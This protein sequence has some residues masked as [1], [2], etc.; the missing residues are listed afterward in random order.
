MYSINFQANDLIEFINSSAFKQEYGPSLLAQSVTNRDSQMIKVLL[1]RGISINTN[2]MVRGN[3]Y[4]GHVN[5]YSTPLLHKVVLNSD[6]EMVQILLDHG[7]DPNITDSNNLPPL[8]RVCNSNVFSP[9]T[10]CCDADIMTPQNKVLMARILLDHGT[11]INFKTTDE[12]SLLHIINFDDIEL[13][14]LLLD[15][16]INIDTSVGSYLQNKDVSSYQIC[17]ED[18]YLMGDQSFLGNPNKETKCRYQ[19]IIDCI[20]L[21][22]SNGKPNLI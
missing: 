8:Y 15:R 21:Y 18:R 1:D 13:V 19:D 2:I 6:F 5:Y 4:D 20:I 3:T 16:N 22:Q 10:C 12:K 14:R 9:G 17:V 7:A 11:N